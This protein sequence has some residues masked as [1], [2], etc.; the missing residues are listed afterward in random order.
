MSGIG[1]HEDADMLAGLGA[2]RRAPRVLLW[3]QRGPSMLGAQN[4][5]RWINTVFS[6]VT[7]LS[8]IVASRHW[9]DAVFRQLSGESAP[10]QHLG[11]AWG[12]SV[13][14]QWP[15]SWPWGDF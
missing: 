12:P 7:M 9:H 13:A 11:A 4:G 3:P 5:S 15:A 2:A 14:V 10:Q 8:F 6:C 1:A